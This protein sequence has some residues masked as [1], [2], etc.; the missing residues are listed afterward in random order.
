MQT[1]I[2]DEEFKALLPTLDKETYAALEEN[3]ITNGCRDAL[4]L[5]ND[6]LIDGHNRYELCTKHNIA[7]STISKECDS[8][9]EVLIWIISNQVSRRN[10]TQMQLSFYRG[11]HFRTDKKIMKNESGKNQYSEQEEVIHHSDG[12]PK[13]Q[14]TSSRLSEKYNVSQ[15]TIERDARVSEAIDAIG[16]ISPEAKIKILSG[17]VDFNKKELR[18]LAS[19][20]KEEIETLATKIE[21]GTYE[22]KA[23][24]TALSDKIDN[25]A[26]S[27]SSE[28]RRLDSLINNTMKAFNTRLRKL[29]EFGGTVEY[30][31]ALRSYINTLE[32]MYRSI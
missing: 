27:I 19:K 6:I 11:L 4:I 7:F 26:D 23:S 18:E 31:S 28:L 16:E 22:R 30:K 17:E 5:W 8:R 9:E 32:E 15:A 12:K 14:S 24:G 10:M 20:P 2:I 25:L 13:S 21:D 1:I 3:L 29:S